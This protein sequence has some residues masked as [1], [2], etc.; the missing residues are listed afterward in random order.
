MASP[1]RSI[2]PRLEPAASPR[3]PAALTDDLLEEI[4]LRVD[5]YADLARASTACV[6]FRGLIADPN[7][8]R[9]YHSRH[10]PLLLGSLGCTIP[11]GFQPVQA[12]HPKAPASR[13]LGSAAGFSFDYLANSRDHVWA[14]SDVCDG[15]VLF[16]GVPNDGNDDDGEYVF[17]LWDLAVCDPLSRQYLLLPVPDLL[18]S[19]QIKERN[20]SDSNA[21]LVPSGDWGQRQV[22]PRG[23][24][25]ATGCHCGLE[26]RPPPPRRSPQGAPAVAG[27][28]GAAGCAGRSGRGGIR[29]SLEGH[30][31]PPGAAAAWRRG[32]SPAAASGGLRGLEGRPPLLGATAAWRSEELGFLSFSIQPRQ[33]ELGK[34]QFAFGCCYWKVTNLNKLLKLD[35][36]T[37]EFST[38]DL[39][40][41]LDMRSW[42]IAIVEA[43]EGN[44]G[45]FS[46]IYDVEAKGY[47][48]LGSEEGNS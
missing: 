39:P 17:V 21:S 26:G 14:P 20:I 24:P 41:D 7:F 31:P 22:A 10:P 13:A 42:S 18:A 23:V 3:Q 25:A 27:A 28:V 47:V 46:L 9:R 33:P 5:S 36:N 15:R 19:V 34:P 44:I 4:L 48:K 43:G 45:I 16:Y 35:M 32:G 8:L 2:V 40:P 29:M 37:L 11:V 1:V 30:P 38:V 12:P 6:S